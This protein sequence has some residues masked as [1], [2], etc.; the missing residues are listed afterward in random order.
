MDS[1]I[2]L[3]VVTMLLTKH[4]ETYKEMEVF[5]QVQAT[6]LALAKAEGNTTKAADLL[7]LQRT[8]LI[9]RCRRYAKHLGQK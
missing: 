8:T 4:F 7:G 3:A 9:M 1:E 6:I 2:Y 5:M